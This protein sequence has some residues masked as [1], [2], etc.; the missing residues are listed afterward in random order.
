[1]LFF[2]TVLGTHALN[3][4]YPESPSFSNSNS[5]ENKPPALQPNQVQTGMG[6]GAGGHLSHNSF[7][8]GSHLCFSAFGADLWLAT[9]M[10]QL[11]T[12]D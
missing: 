9:A 11:F 1:M 6:P 5:L 3:Y 2:L 7:S 10:P 12:R 8:R 4:S